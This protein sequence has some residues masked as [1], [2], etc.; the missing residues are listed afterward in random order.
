VQGMES[1]VLL[2]LSVRNLP[3]WVLI[4][5]DLGK[6]TARNL[7]LSWGYKVV[8]AGSDSLFELNDKN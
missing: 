8:T 6:E 7:L 3:R 2:G 5:E 1:D 4:E